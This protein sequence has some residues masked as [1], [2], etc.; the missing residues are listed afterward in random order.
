M[1]LPIPIIRVAQALAF[2]CLC[3]GKVSTIRALSAAW[4]IEINII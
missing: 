2:S 3:E 4:T 1:Q